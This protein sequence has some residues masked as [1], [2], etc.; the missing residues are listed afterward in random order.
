MITNKKISIPKKTKKS[1][2]LFVYVFSFVCLGVQV[3]FSKDE[4]FKKANYYYKLALKQVKTGAFDSATTSLIKVIELDPN[5]VKAHY[6][7]GV[8][9]AKLGKYKNAL[10]EW[11]NT[12]R[13]QP[14]HV[15]AHF[16]IGFI[17]SIAPSA[18]LD[19]KRAIRELNKVIEL[20]PRFYPAYYRLIHIHSVRTPDEYPLALEF[21]NKLAK[22]R[23]YDGQVYFARAKVYQKLGN[24]KEADQDFYRAVRLRPKE[25]NIKCALIEWL[26]NKAEEFEAI[27]KFDLARKYINLAVAINPKD[28]R[29][30]YKKGLFY[31]RVKK[32]QKATKIFMD[33]LKKDST[34]LTYLNALAYSYAE[35]NIK[36]E[37]AINL[38]NLALEKCNST[39]L[40]NEH[41]PLLLDTRGWI[42]FKKGEYEN[43]INDLKSALELTSDYTPEKRF[44]IFYHLGEVYFAKG[45]KEKAKEYFE[46]LLS[47]DTGLIIWQEVSVD[48]VDIMIEKGEVSESA[49]QEIIEKIQ[50]GEISPIKRIPIVI[51]SD[52]LKK[53]PDLVILLK[54]AK[55][56]LESL[57]F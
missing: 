36:L 49:E 50:K 11:E 17:C 5:H 20:N 13:L 44:P 14:N 19:M 3:T 6:N 45:E 37:Y 55:K 28:N 34:N 23:P 26:L 53:N 51:E 46:K 47:I 35:Q 48:P 56:R 54:N 43:A 2:Y 32:P 21:A 10:K 12:L 8:I 38:I 7:L 16:N 33:L 29:I 4:N 27:R 22:L 39:I 40:I 41:K 31:L 42:Y 1:L 25:E 30:K 52:K 9:Y 18:V 15:L 57:A 24:L